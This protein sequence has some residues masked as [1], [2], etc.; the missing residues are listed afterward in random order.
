MDSDLKGTRFGELV[1]R[2]D[3]SILEK[4]LGL[5]SSHGFKELRLKDC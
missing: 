1:L 5:K 4:D 3:S 2:L